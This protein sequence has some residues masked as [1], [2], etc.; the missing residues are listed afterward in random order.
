MATQKTIEKAYKID[1]ILGKLWTDGDISSEQRSKI[2]E[3][4]NKELL[5]Y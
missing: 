3:V 5:G 1:A 4:V 2:M